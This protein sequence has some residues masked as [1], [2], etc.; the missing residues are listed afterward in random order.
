MFSPILIILILTISKLRGKS[1][2]SG[3]WGELLAA[4]TCEGFNLEFF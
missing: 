2:I 3:F 1:A 4:G